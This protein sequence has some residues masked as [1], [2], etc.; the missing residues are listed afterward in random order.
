MKPF[1]NWLNNDGVPG[2]LELTTGEF[3]I[4]AHL[5]AT[6]TGGKQDMKTV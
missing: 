1:V 6:K 5:V 4:F 3:E 2:P